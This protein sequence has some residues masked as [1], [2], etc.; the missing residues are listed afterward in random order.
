MR[1][2]LI[3]SIVSVMFA[4]GAFGYATYQTSWIPLYGKAEPLQPVAAEFGRQ[5]VAR[6]ARDNREE[7]QWTDITALLA[8][9]RFAPLR[10]KGFVLPASPE[11]LIT[12]RANDRFEFPIHTNGTAG[13]AGRKGP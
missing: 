5:L 11:F 13:L 12:I 1:P 10:D 3:L 4:L 6:L 9:E 7:I 8:D 2:H